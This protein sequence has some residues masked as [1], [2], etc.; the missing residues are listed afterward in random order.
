[1]EEKQLPPPPQY[2]EVEEESD[3]S[4][5]D[6]EERLM[7]EDKLR[8]Q[9]KNNLLIMNKRCK[10]W[11]MAVIS[12][13]NKL[14]DMITATPKYN[15]VL[16]SKKIMDLSIEHVKLG[17]LADVMQEV[18]DSLD[19]IVCRWDLFV[20]ISSTLGDLQLIKALAC[21]IYCAARDSRSCNV[22]PLLTEYMRLRFGDSIVDCMQNGKSGSLKT[23]VVRWGNREFNNNTEI[24]KSSIEEIWR[25]I[26]EN[27]DDADDDDGDDN[28]KG[29]NQKDAQKDNG[30][31][32]LAVK[33][34]TTNHDAA[35]QDRY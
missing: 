18:H 17:G 25:H 9:I 21:L 30:G 28:K 1:M 8:T 23:K 29:G 3:S 33:P 2:R 22:S 26:H 7:M 31:V 14:V 5:L 32:M 11:K 34:A 4:D 27:S 15:A 13:Q 16:N 20:S 10:E 24:A 19:V 6:D 12:L 35:F